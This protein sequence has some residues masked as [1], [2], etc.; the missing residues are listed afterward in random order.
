MDLEE[1]MEEYVENGTLKE[2]FKSFKTALIVMC[3]VL[4][5][6]VVV[7]AGIYLKGYGKAT[8][9]LQETIDSQAKTI[10]ELRK[11]L[12]D[13]V[14]QYVT[15]S[16]VLDIAYIDREIKDIGE[17][18][19][20]EYLYTNAAK[21]DIPA[22]I[23]KKDV[24]FLSKTF[25]IKYDGIVKAGID[26]EKVRVE[27]NKI[28][29]EIIVYLPAAEILSHE[30]DYES[31]ETLNEKDNIFNQIKTDDVHRFDAECKKNMEERIIEIGVLDKAYE[32]AKTIIYRLIYTDAVKELEYSVVFEQAE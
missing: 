18:A 11:E 9:K 16:P 19:T 1:R 25:T 27:E 26:I 17:M 4:V 32:N 23:L 28:K 3:I 2:K 20:I 29:K 13:K 22:E 5:G 30:L 24:K 6:I 15:V 12:D 10:A 31:F 21:F 14:A 7:F 8:K